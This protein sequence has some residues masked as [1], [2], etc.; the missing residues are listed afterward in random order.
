MG[1]SYLMQGWGAW[2]VRWLVLARATEPAVEGGGSSETMGNNRF[3]LHVV[4]MHARGKTGGIN[5]GRALRWGGWR[6]QE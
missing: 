6:A 5:F 1:V 2:A 4:R 3:S